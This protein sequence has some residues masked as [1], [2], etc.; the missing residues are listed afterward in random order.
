MSL[1]FINASLFQTKPGEEQE[2]K[3]NEYDI[4]ETHGDD[5]DDLEDT[6]C[7]E[8]T[9]RTVEKEVLLQMT[10]LDS[11]TSKFS[12]KNEEDFKK[13]GRSFLIQFIFNSTIFRI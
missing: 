8:N 10:N 5:G 2:P 13:Q 7:G 3:M 12:R 4:I 11:K 9:T 6:N 1:F